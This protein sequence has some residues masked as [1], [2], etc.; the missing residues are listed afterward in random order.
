[1]MSSAVIAVQIDAAVKKQ[2]QLGVLG[3][4]TEQV[5]YPVILRKDGADDTE[6]VG[7]CCGRCLTPA[8]GK[9]TDEQHKR[10]EKCK[11]FLHNKKPPN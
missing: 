2:G 3:L 11:G 1:M 5:F 10:Q 9:N 7:I 8:A 6:L 4:V